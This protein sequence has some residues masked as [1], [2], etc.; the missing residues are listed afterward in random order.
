[1]LQRLAISCML[2][3]A[4]GCDGL[5][6]PPDAGTDAGAD[7]GADAGK[8]AGPIDAGGDAGTDGGI[9]AGKPDAGIDAGAPVDA[10]PPAPV[11]IVGVGAFS[12][13]FRGAVDEYGIGAGATP[14]SILFIRYVIGTSGKVSTLA[15]STGALA[16]TQ[17][18]DLG[19]YFVVSSG[20]SV[21][22]LGRGVLSVSDWRVQWLSAAGVPTVRSDT[23]NVV[24]TAGG[25]LAGAMYS[26]GPEGDGGLVVHVVAPKNSSGTHT[27]ALTFPDG[28]VLRSES[29][30]GNTTW[31][32]A[33]SARGSNRRFFLGNVNL[34][35][36]DLGNGQTV[37]PVTGQV[38]WVLVRYS[39][40]GIAGVP[41]V[42]ELGSAS[43][44][45][46]GPAALGAIGDAVW[47]AYYAPTGQL[48]L[49][50]WTT[51]TVT[52]QGAVQAAGQ[53]YVTASTE[54][55]LVVADV[56]P[57]PARDRLYV[58][59]TVGDR[60]SSW[61]SEVLPVFDQ[62]TIAVFT[63]EAS[64][65]RLLG[66]EWVPSTAAPKIASSMTLIDEKLV[67]SG[68]CD[69]TPSGGTSDPLC[70]STMTTS[71]S[72]FLFAFPAP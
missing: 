52:A 1:M 16:G 55:G 9:D 61:G 6:S 50:R 4:A 64:T 57:H 68:Y 70:N 33:A 59:V 39:G 42:R 18:T 56:V 10:G 21:G 8:D 62:K 69:G 35:P 27:S 49:E 2:A 15:R 23:M 5:Y 24:T 41:T 40:A 54:L 60:K 47:I 31:W 29:T 51:D 32:D 48:R 22:F 66:V 72:S 43:K 65:K 25:V 38:Q 37:T 53:A 28:G 7:A 26:D 45:I 17:T 36:C 20:D 58:A 14:T 12:W 67:V 30:C 11:N 34:A 46:T 3:I 19:P 44:S 13:Y 63:F 71:P